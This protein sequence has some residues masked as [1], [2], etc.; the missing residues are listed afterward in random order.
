MKTPLT[1]TMNQQLGFKIFAT[2]GTAKFL[3]KNMI[4]FQK[5]QENL[6]RKARSQNLSEINKDQQYFGMLATNMQKPKLKTQFHL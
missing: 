2:K 6:F 1:R 3:E 4:F 5:I